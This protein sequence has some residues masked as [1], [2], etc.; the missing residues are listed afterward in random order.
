M[1]HV[2]VLVAF[3]AAAS[4]AAQTS[5]TYPDHI[6]YTESQALTRAVPTAA[7]EGVTLIS[8]KGYRVLLC[9]EATRTLTAGTLRAYYFDPVTAVWMRNPTLDLTIST[10]GVRCQSFPDVQTH[11]RRGRVL[12]ATDS[13]TVS[14]G[15]TVSLR[16]DVWVG[17]P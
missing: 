8:A 10:S 4:A 6:Q 16:I 13:V 5:T 3:L 17:I 12:Y 11:V 7:T 9:A 15:T 2:A 1:R 14:A